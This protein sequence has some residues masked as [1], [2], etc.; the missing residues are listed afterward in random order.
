MG[1]K[2]ETKRLLVDRGVPKPHVRALA[3]DRTI[4]DVEL[5][6]VDQIERILGVSPA[7]AAD[8]HA[9]IHK[10][11]P[12]VA[13]GG[14]FRAALGRLHLAITDRLADITNDTGMVDGAE[15]RTKHSDKPFPSFIGAHQ[16]DDEAILEIRVLLAAGHNLGPATAASIVFHVENG[17]SIVITGVEFDQA[18][19]GAVAKEMSDYLEEGD[20][21]IIS[22]HTDFLPSTQ[23]RPIVV[24]DIVEFWGSRKPRKSY[25][26]RARSCSSS[27][28]NPRDE[29]RWP[30][31][32]VNQTATVRYSW[33]TEDLL[34]VVFSDGFRKAIHR[35]HM[36]R[37]L[38][39]EGPNGNGGWAF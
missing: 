11:L 14:E 10:L 17:T 2:S 34:E 36:I 26:Y 5:L 31:T 6:E 9:S 15:L 20:V 7:V 28:S 27:S 19:L 3:C 13:V 29:Y 32:R 1:V 16:S 30:S 23:D 25:A 21:E 8:I 39:S 38:Q 24:G 37:Q 4:T 22:D 33:R 12:F 18:T 35:S